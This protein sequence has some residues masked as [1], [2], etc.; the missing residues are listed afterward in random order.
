[1]FAMV[2]LNI[3]AIQDQD[4]CNLLSTG[5]CP[6]PTDL[7]QSLAG[8]RS[9]MGN[10]RKKRKPKSAST[11]ATTAAVPRPAL[12]LR[13]KVVF[14][15]IA[16]L[17][18][19]V[20]LELTLLATGFQ[21]R[22]ASEDPYVG[23]AGNNPLFVSSADPK[24][25]VTATNK[26]PW[27]NSQS[28]SK[29][30][31]PGTFRI[32]CLGGSTT[33]GRPY[34]DPT[35]F[36]GWMRAYLNAPDDDAKYEVINCG[37]ISYASYRVA[38]VLEEILEYDADLIVVYTGHNEFLEERTY[39]EVRELPAL[40]KHSDALLS[41]TR[42]YSLLKT[43]L[44]PASSSPTDGKG[45]MP[46]EVKTRLDS[47]IGPNAF[48]RDDGLTAKI[49]KQYEFNLDRMATLAETAKCKLMFVTP[50]AN[51]GD[52]SPFK[53]DVA[54]E[55]PDEQASRVRRLLSQA[56]ESQDRN[57]M[58]AAM[59]QVDAGLS[60][61]P[62]NPELHYLRGK[63]LVS[64]QRDSEAYTAFSAACD[65][66]ICTLRATSDMLQVLT[67][68]ANKRSIPLVDFQQ[69]AIEKSPHQIPGEQLFL[70]HVHP[71][72]EGHRLLALQ[73]LEAMVQNA[74]I[75]A[76]ALP[77]EGT[78]VV[79][80]KQVMARV[81][82]QAQGDA[83]R[84]LAK[85]FRWAGKTSEADRMA[86]RADELVSGD[87]NV[88]YLSGNALLG[89][90]DVNEAIAK[91]EQSRQLDPQHAPTW[92]SLGVAYQ[93]KGQTTVAMQQF[94]RALKLEPDNL[95]ALNNL[96]SMHVQQENWNS[97]VACLSRAI[98][99]NPRYAKAHQNL[100][101]VYTKQRM[102]SDA[103]ASLETSLSIAPDD[104]KSHTDLA[105]LYRSQDVPA[106][107]VEHLRRALQLDPDLVQQANSLA[108]ILAT[109][110][111]DTVRN[112]TDAVQWAEFCA[113]KTNFKNPAVFGTLAA[114]YAESGDFGKAVQWQSRALDAAP[115]AI[116]ATLLA[117][118]K[119]FQRGQALRTKTQ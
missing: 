83:L 90:G 50:T 64:L 52:C 19:F 17:V 84:N 65:N 61:D 116:R 10:K 34:S 47:G 21:P 104:S 35:S 74:V 24:V 4:Y 95:M 20:I 12:S 15:V 115:A 30:K 78:R 5:L 1:M 14:A 60:I 68:V 54:S 62:R 27:F 71:T 37:G 38:R 72:I 57:D 55:L 93:S 89:K 69:L 79:V 92:V 80:K 117:R 16:T 11:D 13:K 106:K 26:T 67:D 45:L 101:V 91:L 28:F 43:T 108:W 40:L 77:D 109:S 76:T 46:A 81:D 118:L 44:T 94:E 22:I 42:S 100:A 96:A 31:P 75:P 63:I 111:D 49:L 58:A 107:A 36:C 32:F 53:S 85:V 99:L 9:G 87:A 82:R 59:Q 97:A 103:I 56:V 73:L 102:W 51:L 25:V 7:R 48:D 39:R 23:F 113:H 6:K 3:H 86:L 112:A 70:D 98:E 66:D 8:A 119:K 105:A 88:L 18:P 110:T 29:Q 41:N 2:T 114:A 33:Y